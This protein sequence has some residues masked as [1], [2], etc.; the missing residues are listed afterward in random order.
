MASHQEGSLTRAAA[1][2]AGR[3]ASASSAAA[4]DAREAIALNIPP[5]IQ[6]DLAFNLSTEDGIRRP[7]GNLVVRV[8]DSRWPAT[9]LHLDVRYRD[10]RSARHDRERLEPG[11]TWSTAIEGVGSAGKD[12]FDGFRETVSAI[13]VTFSDE[14][15]IARYEHSIAPDTRPQPGP[16]FEHH[17]HRIR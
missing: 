4:A 7:T 1:G 15:G 10:A 5:D 17:T 14:R 12:G 16:Y 13:V 2:A 8:M 9:D 3:S 6:M 11:E